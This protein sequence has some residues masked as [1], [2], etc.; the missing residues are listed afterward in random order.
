MYIYTKLSIRSDASIVAEN[1]TESAHLWNANSGIFKGSSMEWTSP[2]NVTE[3]VSTF[4]S[5]N[6][7]AMNPYVAVYIWR[8][9]A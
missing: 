1:H 9:T 2:S 5:I 6:V 8:R 4:G 7:P 3:S